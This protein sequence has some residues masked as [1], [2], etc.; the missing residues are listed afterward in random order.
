MCVAIEFR[1][2]QYEDEKIETEREEK[3]Y[4]KNMG[5][6][7]NVMPFIYRIYTRYFPYK[8]NIENIFGGNLI[9]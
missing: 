9:K 5:F 3:K 7:G 8:K 1:G 2:V 6:F 4:T